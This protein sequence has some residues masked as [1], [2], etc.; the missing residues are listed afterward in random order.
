MKA[1]H[2]ILWHVN[3]NHLTDKDVF[4]VKTYL[5]FFLSLIFSFSY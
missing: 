3:T 2:A 4:I 5:M 1:K